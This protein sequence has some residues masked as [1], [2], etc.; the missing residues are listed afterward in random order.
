MMPANP[1]R[2][3]VRS[4][5]ARTRTDLLA[6]RI[7]TP[8]ARRTRSSALAHR[9]GS[10]TRAKG[11]SSADVAA[12][13][14]AYESGT[15]PVCRSPGASRVDTGLMRGLSALF[16]AVLLVCVGCT[17]DDEPEPKSTQ[18]SSLSTVESISLESLGLGW[19]KAQ[20]ALMAKSRPA[21]PAGFNDEVLDRM[22]SL[23]ESWA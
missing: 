6:T 21:T 19:P 20:G 8:L 7:G 23:L 4:M 11:V 22:A 1:S 18:T 16:I 14:R 17:D 10:S 9:A 2:A 12:S 5:I 3:S 15:S 13:S